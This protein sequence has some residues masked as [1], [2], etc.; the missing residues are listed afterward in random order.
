MYHN[1]KIEDSSLFPVFLLHCLLTPHRLSS[2]DAREQ[3]IQVKV[4]TKSSK[5]INI[6][7]WFIYTMYSLIQIVLSIHNSFQKRDQLLYIC[8]LV[9]NCRAS[10]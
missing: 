9:I 3:C 2:V 1:V 7:Y 8:V 6:F 10:V 4:I 5:I